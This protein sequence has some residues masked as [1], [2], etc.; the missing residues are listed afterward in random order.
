MMVTMTATLWTVRLVKGKPT[1]EAMVRPGVVRAENENDD[2]DT[3]EVFSTGDAR[4]I[5]LGKKVMRKKIAGWRKP[6]GCFRIEEDDR[7]VLK[8]IEL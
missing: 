8:L 6:E 5:K 3:W 2:V 7:H 4:E 1:G